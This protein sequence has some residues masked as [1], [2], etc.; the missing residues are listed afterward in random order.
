MDRKE[1][2]SKALIGGG[3]LFLSPALLN[4][5]SK[6]GDPDPS[7]P[8][9]NNN[10]G[11]ITVDLTSNDF[12]TLKTVGG[13]AYSGNIIII[14]T[15][16]TAYIALSK[17]CTHQSCTVAY[18]STADRIDCPCHGSQY[19]I[20]GTVLQGPAPNPLKT[21]TVKVDGTTLKIS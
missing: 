2:F 9:G 15:S 14:R 20:N 1:F 7:P 19:S 17:V 16:S 10:G 5:C 11:E 4:S 3:L 18:N 21:Y 13:F 8:G 6:S 12:S